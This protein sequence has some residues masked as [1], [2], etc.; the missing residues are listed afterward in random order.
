MKKVPFQVYLDPRDCSLLERLAGRLGLSKAETMREAVRR[1]AVELGAP[2]DPMLDLIG[3]LDQPGLPTD[4]STR[5]DDYAVRGYAARR[6]AEPGRRPR[7][8]R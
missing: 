3:S 6:V 2:R 4:L 5:H 8:E 1:W 7:G